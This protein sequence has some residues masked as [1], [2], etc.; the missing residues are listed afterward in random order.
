MAERQRYQN[1]LDKEEEKRRAGLN[2]N[3]K[4]ILYFEQQAN[5]NTKVYPKTEL[6]DAYVDLD[7][8]SDQ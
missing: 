7:F 1:A 2:A 5:I 4:K 6:S 3:E 8:M